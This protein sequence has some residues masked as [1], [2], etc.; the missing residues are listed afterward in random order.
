VRIKA[1]AIAVSTA[2]VILGA[3]ASGLAATGA[4][5]GGPTHQKQGRI[6]V[7]VKHGRVNSVIVTVALTK[8][9]PTCSSA[10]GEGE[11]FTFTK[12]KVKVHRGKFSGKLGDGHGDT[13]KLSGRVSRA[14]VKGSFLVTTSSAVVGLPV[15]NTGTVKFSARAAGGQKA[16]ARYGGSIG[17]GYPISF[18]VSK[19]GTTIDGLT[20]NFLN[21]CQPGAGTIAPTFHFG[22]LPIKSGSF[23]G[24]TELGAG[25]T[26]SDSMQITGSFFGKVA[27]GTITDTAH[28]KSL[29]D[30]TATEPFS[31]APK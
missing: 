2:A 7:A 15:C 31:A 6:T 27:T 23:S 17:A 8:G 16:G 19:D 22:P 4:Q 29:P 20:L 11:R 14:K 5:Y 1:F 30:C 13:M 21:T 26:V 9:A 28:I 3:P 24:S 25:G 12:G 18:T 10:F